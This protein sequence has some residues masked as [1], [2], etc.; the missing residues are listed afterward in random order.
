LYADKARNPS[1]YPNAHKLGVTSIYKD[2]LR[3]EK[4][5][6]TTEQECKEKGGISRQ[7]NDDVIQMDKD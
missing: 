1:Y 3:Q 4:E 6:L 7:S 5:L 2:M